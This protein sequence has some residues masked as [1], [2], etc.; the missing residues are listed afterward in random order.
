[1]HS[2]DSAPFSHEILA[3]FAAWSKGKPKTG[4]LE[5]L[6]SVKQSEKQR[7]IEEWLAQGPMNKAEMPFDLRPIIGNPICG[8]RRSVFASIDLCR[9]ETLSTS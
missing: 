4:T 2:G 8:T 5:V 1:M 6:E 7:A 9:R 3:P